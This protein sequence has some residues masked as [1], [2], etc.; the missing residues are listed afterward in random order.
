MNDFYRK[1]STMIAAFFKNKVFYITMIV[2]LGILLGA[3][4]LIAV[5]T[6]ENTSDP[7]ELVENNPEQNYTGQ[8]PEW[9]EDD[10]QIDMSDSSQVNTNTQGQTSESE[11]G[12]QEESESQQKSVSYQAPADCPVG[13]EYSGS[14]PVFSETLQDWRLH[15][16]IDY[17]SD[18]VVSVF[19]AADGTVEDVYVDGLMGQTVVLLHADGVRTVYQSLSEDVAVQK[20]QTVSAGDLIGYTGTSAASETV[21]GTHVHF[22]VIQEG[23]YCD[24]NEFVS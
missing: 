20:D 11:E 4:V 9:D 19:A 24:P 7:M 3:G 1:R 14:I 13:Q 23:K 5:L 10:T 22:A 17:C 16:G 21:Q 18:D 15:Q 2:S 8:T 12:D 6:S